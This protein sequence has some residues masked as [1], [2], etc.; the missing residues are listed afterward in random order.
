MKTI[1]P[2]KTLENGFAMPVF[3][4][5]TWRMGGILERDFEN[6]DK[7][8]I[9]AIKRAID[10]GITHIDTAE[11]YADGHAETLIKQ[12]IQ[13]YKREDLFL[14]SKAQIK[15]LSYDNL[16]NSAKNSLKRLGTDYLDMYLMHQHNSEIPLEESM[17]A[18][19]YLMIEGLIRNIGVSNFTKESLIEAQNC[20]KNKIV[21]NQ[22]HYNLKYREP[23][24]TGL[25]EYCQN[26]DVLLVAWRPFQKGLLLEEKNDLM[27]EMCKKYNK[28]PAQIGIN[29]LIS[30]KN[31]ITLSKMRNEKHLIE[32]LGALDFEMEKEDVEKLDKNY[33]DQQDISDTV[34][35]G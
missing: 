32:N 14:V 31:V 34:R 22:V 6:D 10:S 4:L 27:D 7:A 3:G 5:G 13:G 29:W 21:T 23:E 16:I 2:T 9:E 11:I 20:S 17:R 28:T 35:L 15:H 33:P 25:L 30:Q 8:D 18:M 12:A 26:N 24:R 1:I 19:D